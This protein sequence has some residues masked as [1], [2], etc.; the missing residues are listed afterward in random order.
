MDSKSPYSN[1]LNKNKAH[2]LKRPAWRGGKK[3]KGRLYSWDKKEIK[4]V[5]CPKFTNLMVSHQR[6]I[7][8]FFFFL[9]QLDFFKKNFWL[10]LWQVEAPRPGIEP[11]P[12]LQ[13]CQILNL[14]SH[15]GTSTIS[16]FNITRILYNEIK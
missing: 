10:Q 8:F 7:S 4:S 12:Q 16:Y 14:P 2:T 11:V 6:T 9:I 1:D 5:P 3:I 15:A 13:Q